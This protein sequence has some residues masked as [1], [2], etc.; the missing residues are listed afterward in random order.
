MRVRLDPVRLL[1]EHFLK[2][3]KDVFIYSRERVSSRERRRGETATGRPPPSAQPDVG[4]G[5]TAPRP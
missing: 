2:R 4:L 3:F 1:G 5:L